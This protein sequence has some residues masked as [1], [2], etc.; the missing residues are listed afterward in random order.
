MINTKVY[1]NFNDRSGRLTEPGLS[2]CVRAVLIGW[3]TVSLIAC[4]PARPKQGHDAVLVE[5]DDGALS[6]H[7]KAELDKNPLTKPHRIRVEAAD[8]VVKLSG[9]VDTMQERNK[10]LELARSVKGV[11]EV[12]DS[13]EVKDPADG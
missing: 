4:T 11:K 7:V 6:A 3:C 2:A 5:R 9:F 1:K 10:A 8:G 12:R 13:L